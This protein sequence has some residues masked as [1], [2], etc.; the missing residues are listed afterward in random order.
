MEPWTLVL[1]ERKVLL[2]S[3]DEYPTSKPYG[4]L[5]ASESDAIAA[6]RVCIDR[7]GFG[8]TEVVAM[9]VTDAM[10]FLWA[11]Q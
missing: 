9:S 7:H 5:F 10:D 3:I 4:L 6:R 2:G 1:P 8:E 11:N